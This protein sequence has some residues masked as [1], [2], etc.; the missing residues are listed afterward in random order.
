[1][2]SPVDF[3]SRFSCYS[4]E[5]NL[6]D[7]LSREDLRETTETQEYAKCNPYRLNELPTLEVRTIPEDS[8]LGFHSRQRGAEEDIST[9]PQKGKKGSKRLLLIVISQRTT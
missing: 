4:T 1:M 8:Q 2:D 3:D 7:Q 6:T 5:T 9:P